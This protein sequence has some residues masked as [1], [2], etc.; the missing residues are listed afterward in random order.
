MNNLKKFLSVGVA[1]VAMLSLFAGCKKNE[2]STEPLN[3][4]TVTDEANIDETNGMVEE[5]TTVEELETNDERTSSD[6]TA[7]VNE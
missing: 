1:T 7:E 3:G 4:T 6:T 5:N 2:E